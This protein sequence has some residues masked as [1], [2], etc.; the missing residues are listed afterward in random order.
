MSRPPAAT[1]RCPWR[2]W[3]RNS[4]S[5]KACFPLNRYGVAC[6]PVRPMTKEKRSRHT[7]KLSRWRSEKS[8]SLRHYP[9]MFPFT[10]L[11][12]LAGWQPEE[13]FLSRGPPGPWPPPPSGTVT[14][15]IRS[16]SLVQFPTDG[17]RCMSG[18]P[19]TYLARVVLCWLDW[20]RVKRTS[21]CRW[22]PSPASADSGTQPPRP[23]GLGG[24]SR[25]RLAWRLPMS[26][27]T[28]ATLSIRRCASPSLPRIAATHQQA[29][30]PLSS[31]GYRRP[32]RLWFR[33][34]TMPFNLHSVVPFIAK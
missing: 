9:S 30:F 4:I 29:S 33:Q 14:A 15:V 22:S 31:N 5:G 10:E 12:R 18:Y 26:G 23:H 34:S 19:S 20:V 16:A 3:D 27:L 11:T 13:P 6:L 7:P 24:W 17:W 2:P 28:S 8:V 25:Y 1:N 21:H 32:M